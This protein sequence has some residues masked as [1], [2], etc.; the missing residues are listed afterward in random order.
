MLDREVENGELVCY[1]QSNNTGGSDGFVGELLKVY[2]MANV[3]KLLL[4]IVWQGD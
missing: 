1:A 4:E 2:G 3:L